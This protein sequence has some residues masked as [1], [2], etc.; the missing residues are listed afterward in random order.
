MSSKINNAVPPGIR[1][2]APGNAWVKRELEARLAALFQEWGYREVITGTVEYE[3]VIARG[4]SHEE[5]CQ[6]YRFF[7]RDGEVLTL[8][9]DMTTPIARMIV[10]QLREAFLPLR[11]FYTANVFRHE[12]VQAGRYREFYQAGVELVGTDDAGADAEVV[13]LAAEALRRLGVE[14]FKIGIGQVKLLDALLRTCSLTENQRLEMKTVLANKDFAAVDD[15]VAHWNL[16]GVQLQ[17][18]E[19]LTGIYTIEKFIS[20]FQGVSS[21]KTDVRDEFQRLKDTLVLLEDAGLR[22]D[23]FVDL[24]VTR[25]FGYYSGAVFEIYSPGL[26]FPICGGGRYDNLLGQFGFDCPATGFALGLERIILVLKRI[27]RLPVD[28][29][30]EYIVGGNDCGPVFRRAQELRK[31]GYYVTVDFSSRTASE[32]KMSASSVGISHAEFVGGEGVR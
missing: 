31:H 1:D 4:L 9:P 24:G 29:T 23:V 18:I 20:S 3:N 27:D 28:E 11:L 15:L 16:K 22:D 25:D 6:L 12:K 2:W 32:L 10:S 19:S 21:K 5:K 26:G 8:R 30:P 17:V 13:I 7:G 14:D